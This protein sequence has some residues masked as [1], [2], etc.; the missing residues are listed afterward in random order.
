VSDAVVAPLPPEE[1]DARVLP[2]LT[3]DDVVAIRA[4]LLSLSSQW[5]TLGRVSHASVLGL[6]AY[7]VR[8]ESDYAARARAVNEVL[9]AS[10]ASLYSRLRDALEPELQ[11][12]HRGDV[13]FSSDH[14]LPGFHLLFADG[15][16]AD[17]RAWLAEPHWDSGFL[18]V[19]W[20][21]ELPASLDISQL[22]SFTLPIALPSAGSGLAIWPVTSAMVMQS[23]VDALDGHAT[24]RALIGDCE[25]TIHAYRV[26]HLFVHTGHHLHA[27]APWA[28]VAGDERITMQGHALHHDGRWRVFW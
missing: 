1:S 10:F 21:P 4:T 24:I 7:S 12:R 5:R 26:G 13:S 27:V 2:L 18:N 28:A 8:G 19:P 17:P 20:M 3:D 15:G 6:P 11:R 16:Q 23:S 9:L 25:P 14:A 22:V